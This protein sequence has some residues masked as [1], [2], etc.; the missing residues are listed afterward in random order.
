MGLRVLELVADPQKLGLGQIDRFE[1]M[2]EAFVVLP[3]FEALRESPYVR[4]DI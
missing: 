1:L 4:A 3:D 2:K